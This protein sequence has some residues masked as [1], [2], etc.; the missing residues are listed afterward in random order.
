MPPKLTVKCCQTIRSTG[1]FCQSM[2]AA[3]T[4]ADLDK[5]FSLPA[6]T[7]TLLVSS[8]VPPQGALRNANPE[9]DAE[10]LA[11][12][13]ADS[14]SKEDR[15]KY[16]T[17]GTH[18][19]QNLPNL[20]KGFDPSSIGDLARVAIDKALVASGLGQL[21]QT[22]L[23]KIPEAQKSNMQALGC[24]ALAVCMVLLIEFTKKPS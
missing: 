10:D 21:I 24:L 6:G 22:F 4:T 11:K 3:F 8:L 15:V 9:K 1:T 2:S 7:R 20:P 13:V 12:E 18:L 23:P 5:I 19:A 16:T 14:L 17:L